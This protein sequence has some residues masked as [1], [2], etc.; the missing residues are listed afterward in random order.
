MV[1][2]WFFDENVLVDFLIVEHSSLYP[3]FNCC[4]CQLLSVTFHFVNRPFGQ[5]CILTIARFINFPFHQL[6]MPSNFHL[7][8]LPFHQFSMSSNFHFLK[9]TQ[10]TQPKLT[11]RITLHNL[12]FYLAPY[13]SLWWLTKWQV[14]KMASWQNDKVTTN[15]FYPSRGLGYNTFFVRNLRIFVII[16]SVC[17]WQAF[18]VLF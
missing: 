9:K 10:L 8:N 15:P 11:L 6:S 18:L 1:P 7:I 13:R 16:Y 4:C 12:Q 14:G 5:S 2:G 17:P 3:T